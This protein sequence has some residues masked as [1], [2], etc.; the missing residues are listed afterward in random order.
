MNASLCCLVYISVLPS[1]W[2]LFGYSRQKWCRQR[3]G[4]CVFFCLRA[5]VISEGKAAAVSEI[6]QL[7]SVQQYSRIFCFFCQHLALKRGKWL[8]AASFFTSQW[9]DQYEKCGE[10]QK[11]WTHSV[12]SYLSELDSLQVGLDLCFSSTAGCDSARLDPCIHCSYRASCLLINLDYYPLR[13]WI[14]SRMSKNQVEKGG[15]ERRGMCSGLS[16]KQ[17]AVTSVSFISWLNNYLCEYE[18]K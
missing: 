16:K 17:S 6:E 9:W 10:T 3:P 13:N 2:S 12:R 18:L 1:R 5:A 7:F 14:Y 8:S 11:V 4:V 15:T